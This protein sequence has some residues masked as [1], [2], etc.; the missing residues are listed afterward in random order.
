MDVEELDHRI[1]YDAK[2]WLD[3]GKNSKHFKLKSLGFHKPSV[4]S[5]MVTIQ[6]G[7]KEKR[8]EKE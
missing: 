2:L 4:C 7:S 5:K 3:S 6:T 8:M 1:I